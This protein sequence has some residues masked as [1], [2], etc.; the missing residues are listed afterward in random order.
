MLQNRLHLTQ[1][2]QTLL[3]LLVQIIKEEYMLKK[4]RKSGL[5]KRLIFSMI[6]LEE[7]VV[8]FQNLLPQRLLY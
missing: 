4:S 8:L 5:K 2:Y 3:S 1:E 7:R 6:F